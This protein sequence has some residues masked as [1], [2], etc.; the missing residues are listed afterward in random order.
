MLRT[1]FIQDK[2]V[3][4]LR[5]WKLSEKLGAKTTFS[6]TA[7]Q[8]A[9]PALYQSIELVDGMIDPA[10][11]AKHQSVFSGLITKVQ[12]YRVGTDICYEISAVD[13]S[14]IAEYR[15][16]SFAATETL[17]GDIIRDR[18]LPL[19]AADGITAGTIA[20]GVLVKKAVFSFVT[21]AEALTKLAT[22]C[23]GDYYWQIANK[24]LTF[25][26]ADGASIVVCGGRRLPD[27]ISGGFFN[28]ELEIKTKH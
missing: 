7:I 4:I 22:L 24:K 6:A 16:C 19:L 18:L 21:V 12:P 27:R 1:L 10:A 23:G 17:A 2:K 28:I 25:T 26:F 11:Q 14:R 20:D 9:V 3:N 13:H 8:T 15:L 5:S